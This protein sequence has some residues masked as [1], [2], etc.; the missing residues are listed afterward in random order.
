[1][2][3]AIGDWIAFYNHRRPHHALGMKTLA[4]AFEIAAQPEQITP[5]RYTFAKV[6][7]RWLKHG[8]FRTVAKLQAAINCFVSAH[9]D[10]LKRFTWRT[11]PSAIIA[12]RS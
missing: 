6:T 11:E 5:G 1:M 12:E 7:R 9:N 2:P 4:A 3:T 10:S 8:V